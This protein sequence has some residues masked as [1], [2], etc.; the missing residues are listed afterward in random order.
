MSKDAKII[1]VRIPRELMDKFDE[2]EQDAYNRHIS[3]QDINELEQMDWKKL[4]PV[5]FRIGYLLGTTDT[6]RKKG[7]RDI[8]KQINKQIDEQIKEFKNGKD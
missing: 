6:A 3:I 2:Y 8:A 5:F 7:L 1:E 4:I